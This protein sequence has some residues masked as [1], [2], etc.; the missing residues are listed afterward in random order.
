MAK[1]VVATLSDR[2]AKKFA[3]VITTVRSPKSGAYAFKEQMMMVD[4]VENFIKNTYSK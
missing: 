4:E 2:K 3:K 1:K